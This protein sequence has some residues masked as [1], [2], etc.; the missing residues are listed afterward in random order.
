M[1]MDTVLADL[2]SKR[3]QMLSDLEAI[4]ERISFVRRLKDERLHQQLLSAASQGML[5]ELFSVAFGRLS[6]PSQSWLPAIKEIE[7]A[8]RRLE[9]KVE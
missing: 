7:Q 5:A 8:S 9:E 4:D 3:A 2:D 1:D 6:L